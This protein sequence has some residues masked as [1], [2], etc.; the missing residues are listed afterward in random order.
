MTDTAESPL[1]PLLV[2][3]LR[4]L[5]P[6]LLLVTG[7]ALLAAGTLRLPNGY[8]V[9]CLAVFAGLLLALSP[10]LPQHLPLVIFGAANQV[11]L[12]RAGMAA[13]A[14]GGVRSTTSATPGK[15]T[16]PLGLAARSTSDTTMGQVPSATA[17]E[18]S[19]ARP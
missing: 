16:S 7:L 5:V 19:R 18:G 13:S 6:A 3:T 15:V 14:S 1:Q 10:F 9:Q 12:S 11:T 4:S 17:T 8:F 2:S